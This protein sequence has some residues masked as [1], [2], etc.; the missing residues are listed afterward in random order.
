MSIG[1]LPKGSRNAAVIE[2]KSSLISSFFGPCDVS[3]SPKGVAKVNHMP[4][5]GGRRVAQLEPVLEHV[6]ELYAKRREEERGARSV[7][8]KGRGRQCAY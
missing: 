5:S 2:H 8:D 1:S 7:Q 3:T 4:K 6:C